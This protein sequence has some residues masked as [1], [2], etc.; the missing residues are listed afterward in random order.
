M[1]FIQ[2]PPAPPLVGRVLPSA[3]SAGAISTPAPPAS[4]KPVQGQQLASGSGGQLVSHAGQLY[5]VPAN[6]NGTA[7][8]AT[9][10]TARPNQ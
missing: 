4:A 6:G 9:G 1:I 8:A 2:A 7:P 5:W 3:A 10:T